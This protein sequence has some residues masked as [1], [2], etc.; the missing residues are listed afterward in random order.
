M[1]NALT[2]TQSKQVLNS[3]ILHFDTINLL[4]E[5]GKSLADG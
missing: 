1:E 2:K 4:L 3:S 5:D